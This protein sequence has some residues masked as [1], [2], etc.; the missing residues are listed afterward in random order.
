MWGARGS[1]RRL[2]GIIQS[3]PGFSIK[4]VFDGRVYGVRKD[5]LDIETIEVYQLTFGNHGGQ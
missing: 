5:K 4:D 3:P 1:V 2:D